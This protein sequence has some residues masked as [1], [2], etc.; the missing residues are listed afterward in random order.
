[1]NGWVATASIAAFEGQIGQAA[2]AASKAGVAALT[3]V[4]HII[5]NEYLN[6]EVIRWTA[7]CACR[8]DSAFRPLLIEAQL[9]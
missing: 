2:Y 8:P 6:G 7:H 1:V 4:Q 3:L 5:E 9:S